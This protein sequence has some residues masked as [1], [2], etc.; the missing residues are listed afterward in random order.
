MRGSLWQAVGASVD[1]VEA[2]VGCSGSLYGCRV[3][4]FCVHTAT[5]ALLYVYLYFI[6]IFSQID[7]FWSLNFNTFAKHLFHPSPLQVGLHPPGVK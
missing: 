6:R 7:R 1:A 2:C 4:S 3:Y 5:E